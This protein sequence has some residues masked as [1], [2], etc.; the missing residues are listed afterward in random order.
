M[1]LEEL[2]INKMS[3]EQVLDLFIDGLIDRNR[4]LI[5]EYTFTKLNQH[6]QKTFTAEEIEELFKVD[7]SLPSLK[8]ILE[9]KKTKTVLVDRTRNE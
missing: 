9:G 5:S 2:L 4:N 1:K 6:F 7:K 8:E 3:K